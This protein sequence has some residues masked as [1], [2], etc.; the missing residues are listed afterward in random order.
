MLEIECMDEWFKIIN[1][2]EPVDP[3]FGLSTI[4]LE[5]E[6][7]KALIDGKQIYTTINCAEYAIIIKRK[8]PA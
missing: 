7:I 6:H 2:G 3:C 8:D 1:P 5:P 4:E